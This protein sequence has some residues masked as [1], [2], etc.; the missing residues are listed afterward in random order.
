MAGRCDRSVRHLVPPN[1]RGH[2]LGQ[3]L[4]I[5]NLSGLDSAFLLRVMS[6]RMTRLTATTLA[7]SILFGLAFYC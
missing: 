6:D 4:F 5:N 1:M 3:L 7:Y 2:R